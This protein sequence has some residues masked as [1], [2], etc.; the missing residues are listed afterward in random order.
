MLHISAGLPHT[1]LANCSVCL[2]KQKTNVDCQLYLD[3]TRQTIPLH[4]DKNTSMHSHVS[5]FCGVNMLGLQFF[6]TFHQ[7]WRHCNYTY[8]YMQQTGRF[9]PPRVQYEHI[10][11]VCVLTAISFHQLTSFFL[12]CCSL[13]ANIFKALY[14]CPIC[15]DKTYEAISIR[16]V[17]ALLHSI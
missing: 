5:A 7:G 17:S 1:A 6:P 4:Q 8:I 9:T 3:F 12:A 10:C 14:Q 11:S 16:C 2:V 13:F 15:P